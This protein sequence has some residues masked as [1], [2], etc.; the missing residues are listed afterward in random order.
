MT[1]KAVKLKHDFVFG[2]PRPSSLFCILFAHHPETM[3]GTLTLPPRVW[4]ICPSPLCSAFFLSG[5][6]Q[7]EES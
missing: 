4:P 6:W 5:F 2:Y 7:E 1:L 3:P